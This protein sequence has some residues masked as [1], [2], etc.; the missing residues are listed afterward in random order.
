M[1][2]LGDGVEPA[3]R[4]AHPVPFSHR[5]K[6]I[7]W[8]D[9]PRWRS[10]RRC[11]APTMSRSVSFNPDVDPGGAPSQPTVMKALP[12]STATAR[13]CQPRPW[14]AALADG[15]AARR[16]KNA[17]IRRA[18]IVYACAL[19]ACDAAQEAARREMPLRSLQRLV[20][21]DD[22]PTVRAICFVPG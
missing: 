9:A 1:K 3:A 2:G 13:C 12:S 5:M 17:L 7:F 10:C 22:P 20:P 15:C 6:S 21:T 19:D 4:G 11:P 18:A 16:P 8:S 14:Q